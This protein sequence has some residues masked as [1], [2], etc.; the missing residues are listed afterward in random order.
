MSKRRAC[1]FGLAP[2][3]VYRAVRVATSAVRS[4]RTVS[5]LPV[6][7]L[8]GVPRWGY[9][10]Q[11]RL[12]RL[13]ASKSGPSAVCSLLHFPSPWVFRLIAPRRYLAPCPMEPG[14]SSMRLPAQR[15]PGQL[16][17]AVY[18]TG[19]LAT[20]CGEPP[21]G[22][23]LAGQ[24]ARKEKPTPE[25]ESSDCPSSARDPA[26]FPTRRARR[27]PGCRPPRGR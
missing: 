25:G 10:L 1:L 15:L 7:T 16:R 20:S 17:G 22:R 11:G 2:G 3:G 9:P 6:S 24:A 8:K 27:R 21:H 26:A 23:V 5:P 13:T 19:V 18:G 12:F 4:Y 14:L